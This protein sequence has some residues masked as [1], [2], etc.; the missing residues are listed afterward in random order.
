[1][2]SGHS[3]SILI[4]DDEKGIRESLRMV[5]QDNYDLYLAET[6]AEALQC[7]ESRSVDIVLLDIMLPDTDGRRLIQ[8]F[9]AIDENVEIIM[10]T[11]IK[12]LRSGI[13]AIKNGAHDYLVK[14]FEVE[15]I[16]AIVAR[17]IKK[18]SCRKRFFF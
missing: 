10:V 3:Y 18:K 14:P 7:F 16:K 2:T 15:N 1:M 17:A 13:D 8:E 4:V 5:L 6:G 9:K 11:A 12:D